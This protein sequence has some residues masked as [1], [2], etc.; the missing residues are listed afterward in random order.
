M[1]QI[2][3]EAQTRLNDLI[4]EHK[5]EI[6]APQEWPQALGY[7]SWVEEVWVNYISNAVKYGGHK[8]EGIMP[9]V[10]LGATPLSNGQIRFWARDNGAGM[11]EKEKNS[12]FTQFTRLEKVKAKGHGL[13][14][15]IVRRI[16]D[17]LGG[18]VGV[19]SQVGQG[20]VFSFTLPAVSAN[21]TTTEE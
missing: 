13:G 3:T 14:L 18:Q 11:T 9:R 6:V 8:A 1:N 20:S 17:K 5:A 19:E 15:S 16:M 10:E 4:K 2:V 7:A 21:S 12:L